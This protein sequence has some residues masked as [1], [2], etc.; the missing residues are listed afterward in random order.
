[1]HV[2]LLHCSISQHSAML[3]NLVLQLHISLRVN[4]QE[5]KIMT[6][7]ALTLQLIPVLRKGTRMELNVGI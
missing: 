1:M 7:I 4:R 6:L 5:T 3:I 2:I